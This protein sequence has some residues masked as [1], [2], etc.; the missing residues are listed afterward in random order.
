MEVSLYL[1][2]ISGLTKT[3]QKEDRTHVLGAGSTE[4]RSFYREKE[5]ALRIG[6]RRGFL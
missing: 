2:I 6:Q 5:T 1:V 4:G 3:N